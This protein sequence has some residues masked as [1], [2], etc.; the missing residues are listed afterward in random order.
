MKGRRW[1]RRL[2]LTAV[3]TM[4]LIVIASAALFFL[5]RSAFNRIDIVDPGP[6]GR[7]VQE[8]GLFANYYPTS[9]PGQHPATLLLG[10]S[11]GGIGEGAD[12]VARTLQEEGFSVLVPSY[13]G[14]PGQ[15]RHLELVPLETFDRALEWLRAQPEV[16]TDQL[17]IAGASKG[18]EAALLIAARHKEVRAVAAIALGL[19][20]AASW[21]KSNIPS[22]FVDRVRSRVAS[23]GLTVNETDFAALLAYVWPALRKMKRRDDKY[24]A[25]RDK[26]FTTDVGQRYLRELSIDEPPGLTTPETTAA[27]LSLC[28]VM[29]M[30]INFVAPAF[31][32]QK[33]T[34]YS[35]T[36]ALSSLIEKQWAVC[37]EFDASIGFHSGSGKS[38]EKIMASNS[39]SSLNC[40][41]QASSQRLE[42][43]RS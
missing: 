38:A 12:F 1:R 33:N 30:K 29:S 23:I 14:A 3:V 7:R 28:E 10:G 2:L 22:E 8:A 27:M 13:F 34:P 35:D 11:E 15:P 41:A 19:A 5:A 20:D 36:A 39:L 24:R 43:A 4:A 16:D 37:R 9:I 18:A 21:V 32:F 31:G 42:T 6:T 26:A 25:A 40:S 17:V